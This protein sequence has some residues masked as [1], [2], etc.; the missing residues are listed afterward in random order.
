MFFFARIYQP[1]GAV[2]HSY[3]L[4]LLADF[5]LP[6][7]WVLALI[8]ITVFAANQRQSGER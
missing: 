2:A 4:G 5:F 3:T 6:V 1:L 8:P 7:S